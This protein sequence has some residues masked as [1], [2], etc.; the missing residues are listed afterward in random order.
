MH[1]RKLCVRARILESK[2]LFVFTG[3]LE[4]LGQPFSFRCIP[5]TAKCSAYKQFRFFEAPFLFLCIATICIATVKT[6]RKNNNVVKI[7]DKYQHEQKSQ[8]CQATQNIYDGHSIGFSCRFTS[9]LLSTV[10]CLLSHFLCSR[11]INIQMG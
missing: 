6:T 8:P 5:L 4:H 7:C 3:L 10:E 11:Y 9:Q 2:P 1:V